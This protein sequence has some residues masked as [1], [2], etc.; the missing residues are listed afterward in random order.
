MLVFSGTNWGIYHNKMVKFNPN[1][2]R[3]WTRVLSKLV[4]SHK[5]GGFDSWIPAFAGMTILCN[6]LSFRR[7]GNTHMSLKSLPF[8]KG[9]LDLP[10]GMFDDSPGGIFI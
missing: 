6:G 4:T 8:V 3:S 1:F 9:D 7:K 10:R 2:N 5:V